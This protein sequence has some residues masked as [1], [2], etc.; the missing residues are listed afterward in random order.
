MRK[1]EAIQITNKVNHINGYRKK[2]QQKENEKIRKSLDRSYSE[3]FYLLMKLIRIDKML[4]RAK[5]IYPKE[6]TSN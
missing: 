2:Y 1:K 6:T 4:K 5:I 3:R